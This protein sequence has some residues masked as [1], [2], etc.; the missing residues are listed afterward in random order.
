MSSNGGFPPLKIIKKESDSSRK[1]SESKERFFIN[2]KNT[3]DINKIIEEV[4]KPMINMNK[5]EIKIIDSF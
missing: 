1:L 2:K 5:D 3:V 4:K